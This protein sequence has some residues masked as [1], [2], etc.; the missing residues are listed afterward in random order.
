MAMGISIV[1]DII[2]AMDI[3]LVTRLSTRLLLLLGIISLKEL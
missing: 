1:M 3:A 2:L